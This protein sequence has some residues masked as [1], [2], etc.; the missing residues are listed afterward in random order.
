[1]EQ[2]ALQPDKWLRLKTWG[3]AGFLAGL[4]FTPIARAESVADIWIVSLM[5][6][7]F[8]TIVALAAALVANH[9]KEPTK[10]V[11]PFYNS[12]RKQEWLFA[13]SLGISLIWRSIPNPGALYI[14]LAA[15]PIIVVMR[16]NR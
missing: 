9:F 14:V 10:T 11:L 3:L 5:L 6:G 4:I 13:L 1:M 12:T 2:S 15:I 8:Y 7:C 16:G